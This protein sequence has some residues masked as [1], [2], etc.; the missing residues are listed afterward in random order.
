MIEAVANKNL[1]T[2]LY[3]PWVFDKYKSN[4]QRSRVLSESWFSKY[5]YCP[6]CLH[7]QINAHPNNRKVADFFCPICDGQFQLKSAAKPFQRKVLDGEFHTMMRFITTDRTPNFFLMEYSRDE[8]ELRNLALIPHFFVSPSMIERRASLSITA[9]RSGWI[10]CNILL[11][12]IPDNGKISVIR[13]EKTIARQLVH[14]QWKRTLFLSKKDPLKR[15][16]T[17]DVLRCVEDLDK[18]KFSLGDMYSFE[19]RLREL[20]PSNMHVRD[21]MRQ[22]LQ[23]LRDNR[24]I[25]FEKPG[26]YELVNY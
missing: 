24:I 23:I 26:R 20:H 15:S 9:R 18:I 7:Q 3:Q 5:M 14:Q 19:K 2:S 25:H 8:W 16:W 12:K 13:N 21:K 6:C 17:L 22:Q 4:S 1:P 11:D 10:G